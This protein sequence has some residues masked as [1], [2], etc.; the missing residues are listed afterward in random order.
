M[1]VRY[2]S[3]LQLCGLY[4]QLVRDMAAEYGDTVTID[5]RACRKRGAEACAFALHW[6]ELAGRT[7]Q[8]PGPRAERAA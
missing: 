8:G 1:E 5:T 6:S 2:R 7:P 4:R 3:N